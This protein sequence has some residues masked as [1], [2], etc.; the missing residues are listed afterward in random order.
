MRRAGRRISAL[1]MSLAGPLMA[2]VSNAAERPGPSADE[3]VIARGQYLAIA[4]DCGACHT[5]PGGKPFAG[6]L[7]L[8]TPLG[9]IFSTI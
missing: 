5:L 3:A 1:L 2:C 4:A 9:T 7:A 6:G 8:S